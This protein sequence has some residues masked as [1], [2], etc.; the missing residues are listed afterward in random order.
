MYSQVVNDLLTLYVKKI[1]SIPL[2]IKVLEIVTKNLKSK[3]SLLNISADI[4]QFW[5]EAISICTRD[6]K[7]VAIACET[8][9]SKLFECLLAVCHQL[10]HYVSAEKAH[11]ILLEGMEKLKDIRSSE[12]VL[13]L[14]Q[15]VYMTTIYYVCIYLK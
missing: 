13:G 10:R 4:E 12:C 2:K 3:K 5:N 9:N 11:L 8:L 6:A 7:D 14:Q 15:M 1:I